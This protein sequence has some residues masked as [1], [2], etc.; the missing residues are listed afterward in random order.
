MTIRSLAAELGVA[1]MSLYR[2]VRDKDDLSDEVVDRFLAT[3]A[4]PQG[5]LHPGRRRR[6]TASSRPGDFVS[7][8]ARRRLTSLR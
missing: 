2:H 6:I 5:G 3:M 7:S 8:S 1:P 4:P